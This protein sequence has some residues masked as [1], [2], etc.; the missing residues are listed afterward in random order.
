MDKSTAYIVSHSTILSETVAIINPGLVTYFEDL[1]ILKPC[2]LKR[3]RW[4]ID[5]DRRRA[6]SPFHHITKDSNLTYT[7]L[8]KKCS[9]AAYSKFGCPITQLSMPQVITFTQNCRIL[10]NRPWQRRHNA[11][12]CTGFITQ[13]TWSRHWCSV[14]RPLSVVPHF[15]FKRFR[16]TH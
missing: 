8:L 10:P 9:A 4:S 15:H 6:P 7:I 14:W 1:H 12:S 3:S 11:Q 2:D 16:F 5:Q 13:H